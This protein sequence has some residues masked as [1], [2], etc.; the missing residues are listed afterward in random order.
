MF[1]HTEDS[2][3]A[4][5]PAQSS[6]HSLLLELHAATGSVKSA[7]LHKADVDVT[8]IVQAAT[9][10]QRGP[11]FV[12]SLPPA[13]HCRGRFRARL[14]SS[15]AHSE[16]GIDGPLYS[17]ANCCQRLGPNKLVLQCHAV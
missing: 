9:L 15:G 11:S 6:H 14:V 1:G 10:S 2:H 8:E 16:L 17:T 5:S 12:V 4:G 13:L 3:V 7:E